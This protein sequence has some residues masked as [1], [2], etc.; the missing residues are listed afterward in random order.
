MGVLR[1]AAARVVACTWGGELGALSPLVSTPP[2]KNPRRFLPSLRCGGF[3]HLNQ[4]RLPV[5]HLLRS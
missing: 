1:P 4:H 2:I 3:R 5:L